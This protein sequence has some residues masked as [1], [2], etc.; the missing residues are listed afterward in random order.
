L[1]GKPAAY[2]LLFSSLGF[3]WIPVVLPA[4]LLLVLGRVAGAPAEPPTAT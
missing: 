2:P 3:T 4:F 1:S